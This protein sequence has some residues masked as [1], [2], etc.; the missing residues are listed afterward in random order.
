MSTAPPAAGGFGLL[1]MLRRG[2]V[3][4]A[5]R[6]ALQ[7]DAAEFSYREL[8][9]AVESRARRLVE[10]GLRPGDRVG[11]L[12]GNRTQWLECFFASVAAGGV[13]VPLSYYSTPAELAAVAVEAPLRLV[14]TE[15]R[16]A[17]RL[18][19]ATLPARIELVDAPWDAEGASA[20]L[21]R[22]LPAL[23]DVD[24]AAPA[25][26]Q[27]TSG[28]SARPKA[29][30]HSQHTIMWNAL[31]QRSDLA[32]DSA[33]VTLVV[34]SLAWGAGLHDL[35]LAT[36]WAGGRVV[37][38]PSQGL[39]PQRLVSVLAAERVSH[40]FI[41]P[42]VIRR[43]VAAGVR[44]SGSLDALRVV[45]TGGEPIVDG[46][47]R[48]LADLLGP[49]PVWRSYGLSEFPSTMTLLDPRDAPTHPTSVGRATSL[50][51]IRVVDAED[52]P[53]PV[54]TVGELVCRSPATMLGYDRDPEATARALRGGWLHT[55]DLAIV[56][57]QGYL[58]LAG[59]VKDMVISGGLN[60]Y[61]ADVEAALIEHDLVDEVA[62]VGVP[63]D[64]WGQV[65]CAHVV[66]VPD[67]QLSTDELDTFLVSRLAA[68]KRPRRYVF[69]TTP[70]PRNEAGKVLKRQ[71]GPAPPAL[72]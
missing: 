60:V 18:D 36:F 10:D 61:A 40:V 24:P 54:G 72:D 58:C 56:D 49:V 57:E 44:A 45:L 42:S 39:D 19:G 4:F 20:N 62:V 21:P 64:E 34:P 9:D 52:V 63:D 59:R 5:D 17:D 35:T 71:L 46:L 33:A 47:I 25:L 12:M 38:Y 70:L 66:S 7:D 13:A 32:I 6:P 22:A 43:V 69:R 41:S 16:Y 65:V 30:L 1:S 8:Y 27:Y 50:A 23:P 31:S 37:V 28:T 53:V 67:A 3:L 26:A 29:V 68:Y 51:E 48:Q 11:I 14:Y 15:S 55:G 2:S